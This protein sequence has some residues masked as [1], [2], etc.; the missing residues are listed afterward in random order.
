VGRLHRRHCRNWKGRPKTGR[1]RPIE[2]FY[3]RRMPR[4]ALLLPDYPR[5]RRERHSMREKGL[6]V[7]D[8]R[9]REGLYRV[10]LGGKNGELFLL[11][12]E[13]SRGDK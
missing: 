12:G 6:G 10:D 11:L 8:Y 13:V 2:K 1:E 4:V 5:E 3:E 7:R 9:Y